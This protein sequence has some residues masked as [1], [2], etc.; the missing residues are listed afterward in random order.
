M[1]YEN[2]C[3]S[4]P[5]R[6]KYITKE[7]LAQ[8]KEFYQQTGKS[9]TFGC[10]AQYNPKKFLKSSAVCCKNFHG[11]EVAANQCHMNRGLGIFRVFGISA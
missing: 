7:D 9:Y 4:C 2:K 3:F 5:N 8:A 11:A 1:L 10:G 6:P